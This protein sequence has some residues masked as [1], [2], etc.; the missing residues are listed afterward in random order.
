MDRELTSAERKKIRRK[1]IF[2]IAAP[3][4]AVAVAII[5]VAALH[6]ASLNASDLQFSEAV[7]GEI[8]TSVSATG[9]VVPS[10]EETV[11]SPVS[12]KI[13]EIYC[14]EGDKVEEGTP[15]LRLDLQAAEADVRKMADELSMRQYATRQASLSSHTFLTNLEMKIKAKEMSVAELSAEV[16]NERRLDSLG[17]GTGDRMRQ[18]ELAYSTGVLEL[19]QMRKELD[20]ERESHDV[21]YKTKKLEEGITARNLEMLRHTLDDARVKAPHAATVMFLNSSI[22]TGIGAGEKLAVLADL[23]KFKITAEIPEGESAKVTPGA[24]T[25]VRIGSKALTGK[26]TQIMP[27]STNGLIAFTVRPDNE[28]HQALKTGLRAE[29]NVVYDVLADVTMI[30]NGQYYKGPGDYHMFVLASDGKLSKKHVVL[31]ESNYNYVEVR[32]GIAPGDKVVIS[33]MTD[34]MKYSSVKLKQNK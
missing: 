1:K 25:V 8:E 22:G 28:S 11:V 14:Q 2:T 18:A 7:R 32:S 13:M 10:Y 6:S 15:L 21:A 19:E 9:K 34:Y 30:N 12:T 20:N 5:G 16:D 4:I 33:D 31:G 23:T 27:Q 24:K 3:V 17:S 26:V 29:V